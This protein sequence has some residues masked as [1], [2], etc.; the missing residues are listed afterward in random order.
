MVEGENSIGNRVG[1]PLGGEDMRMCLSPRREH[2]RNND[3]ILKKIKDYL[4][5][6]HKEE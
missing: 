6:R 3:D 4:S 1:K 2:G 5:P